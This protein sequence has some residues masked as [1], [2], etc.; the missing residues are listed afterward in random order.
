M[1]E[2]VEHAYN[3]QTSPARTA[4]DIATL[5]QALLV[6]IE[7]LR[8][9]GVG[10]LPLEASSVPLPDEQLIGEVTKAVQVLYERQR[11]IQ[12]GAGVIE[13]LLGQGLGPSGSGAQGAGE[14][15]SWLRSW[16]PRGG[17]VPAQD[18]RD[19]RIMDGAFDRDG[20]GG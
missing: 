5:K 12:D 4:A 2:S 11:R 19:R 9:W 18:R 6:L 14:S 13:G 10:A 7:H 17:E 15:Q 1:L 16:G 20:R 8:Q 3:H